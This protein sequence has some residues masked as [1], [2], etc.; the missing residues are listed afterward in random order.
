MVKV[1]VRLSIVLIIGL[2]VLITLA[3]QIGRQRGPTGSLALLQFDQCAPPCW[4][5]IVPGTT[6]LNESHILIDHV[7]NRADHPTISAN[8]M[9]VMNGLEVTLRER[10]SGE[11]ITREV[12]VVIEASDYSN[13]A[14]V[15]SI[16]FR[17]D[18]IPN[19]ELTLPELINGLG[20]PPRV[21]GVFSLNRGMYSLAL[22]APIGV[23]LYSPY[24]RLEWNIRPLRLG[25]IAPP[26]A[27]VRQSLLS[28]KWRGFTTFQR[29]RE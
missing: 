18:K 13:A 6:S 14:P 8:V 5:G 27:A 24:Q 2:V 21:Y 26:E 7:Y 15:R 9:P 19:D 28:P 3:V 20:V 25:F 23:V 12:I 29:Y 17:L 10:A 22:N 1:L 4:I 11:A 16:T